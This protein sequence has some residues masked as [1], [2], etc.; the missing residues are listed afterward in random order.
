MP[1]RSLRLEMSYGFTS[2]NRKY[3]GSESTAEVV[4]PLIDFTGQR[5][6]PGYHREL[7]GEENFIQ[8]DVAYG[9]SSRA[10]LYA[11][12]PLM[13]RRYYRMDHSGFQVAYPS[14]GFGDTVVGF[15]TKVT[16]RLVGGI[17]VKLPT[18]ASEILSPYGEGIFEPTLQPGTG[19]TDVIGTLQFSP[20]IRLAG[21]DLV[22]SATHQHTTSNR[23]NYRFGNQSIGTVSVSRRFGSAVVASAQVK[24]FHRDRNQFLGQGVPSTGSLF[25]YF[26]PG[27]RLNLS[28]GF[29]F[30]VFV[31]MPAYRN[32]NEAQLG[33]VASIVVGFS[34]T[35]SLKSPSPRH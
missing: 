3:L 7:G 8:A 13:T 12:A 4:R 1:K 22:F 15:R 35:I 34:R 31:P 30:Y 23:L 6:L 32:L 18:G 24:A 5:I 16:Q 9:L 29:G 17:G 33:P 26:T 20:P 25:L 27:I 10:T 19:A 2:Q 21:T 14:S 28:S 11:S